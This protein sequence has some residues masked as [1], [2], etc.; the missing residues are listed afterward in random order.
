MKTTIFANFSV[1]T[2]IAS[3]VRSLT[4]NVAKALAAVT[5]LAGMACAQSPFIIWSADSWLVLQSQNNQVGTLIAQYTYTGQANQQ[6]MLH[7]APGTL[8]YEFISVSSHQAL[9]VPGFSHS[10]GT[11]IQ[12]YPVNGGVNQQ[13]RLHRA[14]SASGFEIISM[15][16]G[17]ISYPSGGCQ[18]LCLG[19]PTTLVLDDPGFSLVAGTPVQQYTENGG[20]NQQWVFSPVGSARVFAVGSG[21]A[22][23]FSGFGFQPGAQ[24]CPVLE[25]QMQLSCTYASAT[26]TIAET[27]TLPPSYYS[28]SYN[29][30]LPGLLVVAAEDQNGNVLAINTVAGALAPELTR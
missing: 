13:W 26:G 25:S 17:P 1:N 8:A 10:N 15:D 19:F 24:V 6:W 29:S 4:K 27:V 18:P 3:G 20:I 9:D 23:T 5:V 21:D 22:I 16:P 14:A 12:Q 7:R 28:Q 11:K 30:Q 2:S